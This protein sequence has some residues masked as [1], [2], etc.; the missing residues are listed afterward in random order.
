MRAA[1]LLRYDPPPPLVCPEDKGVC[2]RRGHSL[3][4]QLPY[5]IRSHRDLS[6]SL[7]FLALWGWMGASRYGEKEREVRG[8]PTDA[9]KTVGL[10][11]LIMVPRNDQE[12]IT[13]ERI[14]ISICD[15][16]RHA[17]SELHTT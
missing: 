6:L 2:P 12:K 11:H 1:A 8:L 15:Q 16:R 9:G 7:T 13:V 5:F 17:E 3:Q 4:P 10:D 14:R